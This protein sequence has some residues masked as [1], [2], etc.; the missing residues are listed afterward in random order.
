ME[1]T[2][3]QPRSW[4]LQ[5]ETTASS[6]K[7]NELLEVDLDV[8]RVGVSA[9]VSTVESTLSL[10]ELIKVP[11]G[12]VSQLETNP[13]PGLRRSRSQS[14]ASRSRREAP[15][16]SVHGEEREGPGRDLRGRVH[17]A[18]AQRGQEEGR[19]GRQEARA[20]RAVP[21]HLRGSRPSLQRGLHAR[22][23]G[24]VAERHE[25]RA[26]AGDGG[27]A[28]HKR[29]HGVAEGARGDLQQRRARAEGQQR[30][31]QG[32]EGARA[33]RRRDERAAG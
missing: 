22:R 17:E 32:G 14:R 20:R 5:G 11:I 24:Q 8:D 6:R 29:E 23:G 26:R 21:P 13:R 25:L 16:R 28:A 31:G 3:I 1:S 9:P 19:A 12:S 30:E 27:S 2:L 18:D 15:G 4:E 7:E 10:E 33:T